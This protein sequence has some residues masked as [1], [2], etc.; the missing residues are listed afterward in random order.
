MHEETNSHKPLRRHI[1][2]EPALG[3]HPVL[4]MSLVT[5]GSFVVQM[6]FVVLN[7]ANFSKCHQS[8][9]QTFAR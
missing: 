2:P 3:I 8:I 9:L 7:F 1:V 5:E 4:L 6:F